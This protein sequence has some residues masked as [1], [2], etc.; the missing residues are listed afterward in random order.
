MSRSMLPVAIAAVGLALGGCSSHLTR[1]PIDPSAIPDQKYDV[2]VYRRFM[3]SSYAVLFDIPDDGREVFMKNLKFTQR[4]GK[5]SPSVYVEEFQDRI[6]YY[7]TVEIGDKDGPVRGYLILSSTLNYWLSPAG[8][9]IMV[10][11]EPDPAYSYGLP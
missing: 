10:G 9:R 3:S 6:K 8:E 7:R 2:T 11:I 5:D 4:V 1:T